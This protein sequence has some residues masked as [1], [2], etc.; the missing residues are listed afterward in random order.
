MISK[1]W[2][3]NK[4]GHGDYLMNLLQSFRL[5]EER[6]LRS[7]EMHR[8]RIPQATCKTIAKPWLRK[9][10]KYFSVRLQ[11]T[12]SRCCSESYMDGHRLGTYTMYA[13]RKVWCGQNR[14]LEATNPFAKACLQSGSLKK[15]STNPPTHQPHQPIILPKH[16]HQV[17]GA[18]AC[19]WGGSSAPVNGCISRS[20]SLA[21]GAQGKFSAQQKVRLEE[22]QRFG[23]FILIDVVGKWH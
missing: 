3:H 6:N 23:W 10:P 22:N 15:Y 5:F 2:P 21:P 9:C 11:A 16:Q 13:L 19:T 4:S 7:I 8:I 18:I 14:H 12:K 20:T 1:V 17:I